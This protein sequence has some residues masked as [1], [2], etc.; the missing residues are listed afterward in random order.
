MDQRTADLQSG[1]DQVAEEYVARIF[2]EL[3]HK[4]LDRELLDRFANQVQD[5]GTVCDLGCGPGHIAYYLHRRGV[6]VFGIDLSPKMVERARQLSPGIEFK[7]GDMRSLEAADDSWGGIAAFYSIIH[8]PRDEVTQ[9]LR[10]LRRVLRPGGI[11]LLAFH[12]GQAVIHTDEWWGK[13][14]SIDFV[15]FQRDEMKGYLR[16]AG[17][18]I[19]QAVERPPYANVEYQSRRAYIFAKKPVRGKEYE[20]ILTVRPRTRQ[21]VA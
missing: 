18:E 21:V 11:C 8:I 16:S 2:D 6:N 3:Q 15:F 5:L 13:K 10:E 7:R 20:M 19:G 17:F 14:V 12:V 9:V 4:P 1:Y